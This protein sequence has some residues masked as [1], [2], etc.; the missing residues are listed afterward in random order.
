MKSRNVKSVES[1]RRWGAEQ[2]S[3]GG[4]RGVLLLSVPGQTQTNDVWYTITASSH[5]LHFSASKD[6]H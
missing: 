4:E 1:E 3:A 6:T 5:L 2:P